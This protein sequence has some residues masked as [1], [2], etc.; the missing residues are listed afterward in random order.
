MSPAALLDV[1]PNWVAKY[2][3]YPAADNVEVGDAPSGPTVEKLT[4]CPAPMATAV[5][6]SVKPLIPESV[7]VAGVVYVLVTFPCRERPVASAPA[8]LV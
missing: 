1:V 4:A 8:G 3:V 2:W 7:V 6:K 5:V